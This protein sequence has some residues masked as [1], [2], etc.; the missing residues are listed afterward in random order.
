[1]S[2]SALDKLATKHVGDGRSNLIFVT[3]D[4][5]TVAVFVGHSFFSDAKRIANEMAGPCWVEDKT[6]VT[7]DNLPSRQRQREEDD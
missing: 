3:D 6:G 7:Y 2:R 5:G 1:M 4:N